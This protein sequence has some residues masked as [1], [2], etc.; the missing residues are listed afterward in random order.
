MVASLA[1]EFAVEVRDLLL[2]PPTD[3]PYTALKEQL[4]GLRAAQ[5]AA[6][7]HRG[8]AW[9]LQ[10]LRRMQELLGDHPGSFLQELFLQRLPPSVRMVLASTPTATSLENLAEMADKIIEVAVP[11]S[12]STAAATAPPQL[13][14]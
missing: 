10:T 9:G 5:T 12:A 1:P 3:N 13:V 4:T 7:F 8:G 6:T 2:I 14:Y 11:P